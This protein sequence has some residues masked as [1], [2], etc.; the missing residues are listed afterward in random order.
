MHT[1]LPSS[2]L[3]H[4]GVMIMRQFAQPVDSGVA[5]GSPTVMGPAPPVGTTALPLSGAAVALC[6]SRD[7]LALMA[8]A[9]LV[10]PPEVAAK[11]GLVG[12]VSEAAEAERQLREQVLGKGKTYDRRWSCCARGSFQSCSSASRDVHPCACLGSDDA[13][14]PSHCCLEPSWLP[15]SRA[16]LRVRVSANEHTS[17]FPG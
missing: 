16:M 17:Q 13:T 8:A 7:S 9:M 12:E 10:P 2:S 1:V 3:R 14:C 6:T 4:N 5:P 11:I 15:T